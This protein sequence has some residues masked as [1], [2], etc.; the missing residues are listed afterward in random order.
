MKK[1]WGFTLIEILIYV[2]IV[3][4]LMTVLIPFAWNVIEGGT[5]SATE[6]EVF[7]N[8]RFLSE[9]IKYEI[10]NATNINSVSSTQI[11]LANL[12]PNLNPTIINLSGN[13]MQIQQGSGSATTLNSQ[14]TKIENLTFTNFTSSDNKTK[15]IKFSFTV[16]ANYNAG[17]RQEFNESTTIESSSEIRS[18]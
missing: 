1:S 18:N 4:L 16:S 9:R 3:S 5:K 10:R 13:N 2:S 11:S 14:D 15:H 17:Q 6:R 8:A 7:S 12:N